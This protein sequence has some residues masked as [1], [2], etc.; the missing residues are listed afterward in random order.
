MLSQLAQYADPAM[1]VVQNLNYDSWQTV[2]FQRAT[3]IL[4]ELVLFFALKQSAPLSRV[5]EGLTDFTH[6][7][8]SSPFLSLINTSRMPLACRFCCLPGY[9]LLIIFIFNTTAFC[10]GY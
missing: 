3:V 9:S 8:S 2:Y 6:I 4:T 7:D 1:L 5:S 10:T